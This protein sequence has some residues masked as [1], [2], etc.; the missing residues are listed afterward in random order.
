MH[1]NTFK[2]C[3]QRTVE[4]QVMHFPVSG[5]RSACVALGLPGNANLFLTLFCL[6]PQ[7]PII[8]VACALT[9]LPS[10]GFLVTGFPAE[11]RW[12]RVAERPGV[13]LR[14]GRSGLSGYRFP[15]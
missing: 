12:E 14:I 8:F 11:E 5:C 15:A 10:I 1:R 4:S 3:G 13:L 7:V 9:S 6:I 2:P